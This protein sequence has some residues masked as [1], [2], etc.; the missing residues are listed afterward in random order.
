MSNSSFFFHL[1]EL[2]T[3]GSTIEYSEHPIPDYNEFARWIVS[4]VSPKSFIFELLETMQDRIV[5]VGAINC[6]YELNLIQA[7]KYELN[8]S[9]MDDNIIEIRPIH[10]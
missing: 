5:K 10:A 9:V 4:T 8:E 3:Y 1:S 2:L 7:I 6:R